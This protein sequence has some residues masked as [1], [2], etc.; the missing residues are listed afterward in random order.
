MRLRQRRRVNNEKRPT[1]AK[2]PAVAT[3][4]TATPSVRQLGGPW[5]AQNQQRPWCS[6][7]RCQLGLNIGS[8]RR[9]ALGVEEP[10]Q[11][12]LEVT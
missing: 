6:R 11:L 8:P 3:P 9:L 10:G 7:V 4:I 1:P 12:G 2:A 5:S